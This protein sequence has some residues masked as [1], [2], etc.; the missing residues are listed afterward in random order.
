MS[1]AARY[2]DPEMLII[3][4]LNYDSWQT[5]YFQRA[6]VI[7]TELALLYSLHLYVTSKFRVILLTFAQFRQVESSIAT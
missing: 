3:K 6:T 7:A 1:Q 5:V 4:N 2:V